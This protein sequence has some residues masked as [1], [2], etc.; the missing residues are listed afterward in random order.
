MPQTTETIDELRAR[1]AG[2][3]GPARTEPLGN[4]AQ[5][6]YQRMM[7]VPVESPSARADLD[8]AIRCADEVYGYHRED[9]PQRPQV[10]GFLGFLL[11]FRDSQVRSGGERSRAITLIE[12]AITRGTFAVNYSAI[13][14]VLLGM[15]LIT[16]SEHRLTA[17]LSQSPIDMLTGRRSPAANPDLDRAEQLLLN[18]RE[19]AG[20]TADIL[21]MA[22]LLLQMCELMKTLLGIGTNPFDL[23]AMQGF[24]GRF[25]ELKRRFD[26]GGTGVFGLMRTALEPG[27]GILDMPREEVPVIIM[28]D[29]GEESANTPLEQTPAAT[30]PLPAR[31]DL[32]RSLVQSLSL[33]QNG[34]DTWHNTAR[35]LL[36]GSTAPGVEI[37][38]D[39]VAL[40]SEVMESDDVDLSEEDTALAHFVYAT[41]LCLRQRADPD[42]DGTDYELGTE[43]L[44][45][46]VRALPADHSAVPVMLRSLGAFL[47]PKRPL[48]G[49]EPVAAG[50]TGRLDAALAAGD[51]A[52]DRAAELHALR[53]VCRAAFAAAELRKAIEGLPAD[54]PWPVSL[55][56]AARPLG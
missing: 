50:F 40:A 19:T 10:A 17:M 26:T 15:L 33:D 53:C 32:M 16:N 24:F 48:A 28:E 5:K 27:A 46:A 18:V 4:L 41:F 12:E 52:A 7:T 35:F 49:L 6:L 45:T 8:E 21:D 42:G 25:A 23:T 55:T 31:H 36:P 2:L 37:V 1:L 11:A 38:D 56:A 14:R 51:L 9:D 30:P 13:L 29:D 44:L 3:T 20:V 47:S 43:A 39:T 34:E 54:Y 22:E